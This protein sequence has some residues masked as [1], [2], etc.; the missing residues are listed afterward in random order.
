MKQYITD[1][2]ESKNFTKDDFEKIIFFLDIVK[3]SSD[4]VYAF[5]EDL[6]EF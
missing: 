2:Y 6:N 3:Q 1:V 5:V 4:R